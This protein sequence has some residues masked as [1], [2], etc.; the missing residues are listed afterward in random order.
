MGINQFYGTWQNL[1]STAKFNRLY[2]EAANTFKINEKCNNT[3]IADGK[4]TFTKDSITLK[5]FTK[6]YETILK[7]DK[8]NTILNPDT[9]KTIIFIKGKYQINGNE[10]TVQSDTGKIMFKKIVR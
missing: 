6:E 4:Y 2:F 5:A 7:N 9:T 3:K 1:D 10:L 8:T